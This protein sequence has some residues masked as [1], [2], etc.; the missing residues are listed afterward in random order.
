VTPAPSDGPPGDLSATDPHA[1]LALNTARY[2]SFVV[3][4]LRLGPGAAPLRGQVTHVTS[5]RTAH[6]GT[7]QALISFIEAHLGVEYEA[8]AIGVEPEAPPT[9]P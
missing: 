1:Q 7:V 3:R 9:L 5:R 2:D 4:V 8:P 6:F